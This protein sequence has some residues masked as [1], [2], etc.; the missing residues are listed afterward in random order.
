MALLEECMQKN[1]LSDNIQMD[2]A[3]VQGSHKGIH[4][5]G[6]MSRNNGEKSSMRGTSKEKLCIVCGVEPK[7]AAYARSYNAGQMNSD[8]LRK[9][10]DHI[11]RGS[12][13][14]TDDNKTYVLLERE[15]QVKWKICYDCRDHKADINLNAVN[16]FHNMIKSYHKNH[17]GMATKYLNR[18]CN[19][20]SLKWNLLRTSTSEYMDEIIR[21]LKNSIFVIPRTQLSEYKI[22]APADLIWRLE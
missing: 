19:M 9:F 11:P 7:G 4:I 21:V 10:L 6:L 8:T 15:H 17:R 13:V 18:Y 16:S 3:F 22:Y 5:N 1:I 14:T 2:E 12:T 20:L